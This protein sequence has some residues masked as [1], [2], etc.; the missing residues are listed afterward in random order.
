VKRL[1]YIITLIKDDHEDT[2]GKPEICFVGFQWLLL[3]SC[4]VLMLD[5]LSKSGRIDWYNYEQVKPFIL[6][7]TV[8]LICLNHFFLFRKK[9]ANKIINKYTGRYPLIDEYPTGAYFL[10][11]LTLP[12]VLFIC[13]FLIVG[14]LKK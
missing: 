12:I 13:S 6:F 3:F 2:W 10:F 7:A 8:L 11:H 1:Y 5:Q 9:Q 14:A 4:P